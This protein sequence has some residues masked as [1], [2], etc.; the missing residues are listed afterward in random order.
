MKQ[1]V[2]KKKSKINKL[3]DDMRNRNI[4]ILFE[5]FR[6]FSE[7]DAEGRFEVIACNTAVEIDLLEDVKE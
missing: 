4:L 5:P 1:K 6:P 7:A 3:F 2:V